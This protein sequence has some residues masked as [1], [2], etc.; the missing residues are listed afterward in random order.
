M[1]IRYLN[2]N[3]EM[4]YLEIISMKKYGLM[5]PPKYYITVSQSV[6]LVF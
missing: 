2:Y 4:K 3:L 6:H 5:N 1:H